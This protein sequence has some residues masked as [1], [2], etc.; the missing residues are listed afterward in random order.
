[1]A[2]R[3]LIG[4]FPLGIESFDLFG[5]ANNGSGY[6]NLNPDGGS[7]PFIEVGLISDTWDFT[8]SILLHETLEFLMMRAFVAYRNMGEI[9]SSMED[10]LFVFS[11]RQLDNIC[12]R[13]ALFIAS[14]LPELATAWKKNQKK[15]KKK[16]K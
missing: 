10:R 1:M 16:R 2:N 5:I 3:L 7:K 12:D 4:T 11:H 13:Q 14:A 8:V 6:L 9:Y 15:G